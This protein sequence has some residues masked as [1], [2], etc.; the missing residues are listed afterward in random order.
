MITLRLVKE[1]MAGPIFC[2]DPERMGHVEVDELPIS[3]A[4]K[5]QILAWDSEYQATFNDDYPPDS[6]FGSPEAESMHIAEGSRL[7]KS[8]QQELGGDYM[9]EYYP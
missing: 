6:G 8:L 5:A 3:Q 9:V 7:A 2:P 4:L 1:Y